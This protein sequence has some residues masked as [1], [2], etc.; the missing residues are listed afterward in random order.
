MDRR[1][2]NII[3]AAIVLLLLL[4]GG[5]F[6]LSSRRQGLLEVINTDTGYRE[7]GTGT[8]GFDIGTSA[9]VDVTPETP[10]PEPEPES[11]PEPEVD[12]QA[13]LKRLAAAFAERFGSFSNLSDY[14]NVIDL[15]AFMTP[16]MATWADSYVAE[17]RAARGPSAEYYGVTTRSISVEILRFDDTAGVA[18][19][20][21]K[22]QRR[23]STSTSLDERVFYQ[24]IR[25]E[26]RRSGELWQVNS[27]RWE[28]E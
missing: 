23:E 16:T 8:A 1:R 25:L 14:D 5:L 11:E 28:G 26:F 24:D 13:S 21:V 15:K 17:Q 6:L 12:M 9:E 4:L 22:T 18:E 3:V 10:E 19:L 2:R 20:V 27:A 7:T